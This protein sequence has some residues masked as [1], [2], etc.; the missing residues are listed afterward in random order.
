MI[1]FPLHRTLS[2]HS[3]WYYFVTSQRINQTHISDTISSLFLSRFLVC[4]VQV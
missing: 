1:I 4:F 3:S 2:G